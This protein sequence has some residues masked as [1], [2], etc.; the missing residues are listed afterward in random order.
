MKPC[1]FDELNAHDGIVVEEV[2]WVQPI[3]ANAAYNGCKGDDDLRMLVV[4]HALYLTSITKFVVMESKWNDPGRTVFPE[5]C[6]KV[7][8][9][10]APLPAQWLVH[11]RITVNSPKSHRCWTM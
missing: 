3:S 8:A 6:D 9:Q 11:S 5:S 4:E 10:E 2:A 7:T 1:F